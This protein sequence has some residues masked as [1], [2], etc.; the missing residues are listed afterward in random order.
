M[1]SECLVARRHLEE[2]GLTGEVIDPIWL[3]PLDMDTIA[4]SAD[5]ACSSGVSRAP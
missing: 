3:S 4:D 1:Q 5:E 2:I